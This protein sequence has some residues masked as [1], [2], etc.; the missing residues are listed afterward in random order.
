MISSTYPRTWVIGAIPLALAACDTQVRVVADGGQS[1]VGP[2]TTVSGGGA[3]GGSGGGG[4]G[5]GGAG[6]EAPLVLRPLTVRVE[7]A[8]ITVTSFALDSS[9]LEGVPVFSNAPD[10]SL[11]STTTTGPGGV[12]VIEGVDEGFLSAVSLDETN[13]EVANDEILSV[14]ILPGV[15]NVRVA[16]AAA[17]F[18]GSPREPMKVRVEWDP[19]EDA[20]Y[21]VRASCFRSPY[22]PEEQSSLDLSEWT[23]CPG[24]GEFAVVVEAWLPRTSEYLPM[25]FG[26]VDDLQYV[27]GGELTVFVPLET[28]TEEA[29]VFV[30]GAT[31]Q[32][33]VTD[34][35][36]ARLL[37]GTAVGY[38]RSCGE[39]ELEETG[40]R[41][42]TLAATFPEL[43]TWSEFYRYGECTFTTFSQ[44]SQDLEPIEVPVD[45][46]AGLTAGGGDPSS[47]SR[48]GG[49]QLLE[50][51][52]GD[53]VELSSGWPVGDRYV[54][55]RAVEPIRQGKLDG[56]GVPTL[57]LPAE[58]VET[59]GSPPADLTFTPGVHLDVLE[60]T[61][62]STFLELFDSDQLHTQESS[63]WTCD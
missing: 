6:G 2:I 61:D 49:W 39:R 59:V 51:E 30:T 28:G 38:C 27:P 32:G 15:E 31:A 37:P 20:F 47:G 58:V 45:R 16:L 42:T 9:P 34:V 44:V 18:L 41:V 46:L 3:D 21:R 10:G 8:L 62:Y 25:V 14:R 12:A 63:A 35:N 11:L 22:L 7:R 24:S 29:T 56:D 1:P 19:V 57:E 33:K 60:A 43:A 23:G 26:Y 5:E 54:S 4:G 13:F 17:G 40:V 50:G 48:I 52:I 55:W 36:H 53:A